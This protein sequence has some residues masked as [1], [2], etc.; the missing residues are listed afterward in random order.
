MP[1]PTRMGGLAEPS[2][3]EFEPLTGETV[4]QIQSQTVELLEVLSQKTNPDSNPA[5]EAGIRSLMV[6]D[7]GL[8]WLSESGMCNVE[9]T[10]EFFEP[11]E[12]PSFGPPSSLWLENVNPDRI[13]WNFAGETALDRPLIKVV[14]DGNRGGILYATVSLYV[15]DARLM[16]HTYPTNATAPT[17]QLIRGTVVFRLVDGQWRI[18]LTSIGCQYRIQ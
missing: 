9:D 6:S 1:E 17:D 18:A 15:F 4:A 14:Y 11:I 12:N 2:S 16:V 8:E 7:D 10:I 3:F 13:I 5:V